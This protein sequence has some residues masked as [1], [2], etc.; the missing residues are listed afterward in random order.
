MN[1]R[2]VYCT[3]GVCGLVLGLGYLAII[4]L[5]APIGAP[6]V[7]VEAVLLYLVRAPVRW[8]WIVVLSVLTDFLFVPLALSIY[9]SLRKINRYTM[10][11]SS[12]CMLLF[13]VL[14][15]AITWTN[16]TSLIAL[17]SKYIAAATEAQ[18]SA[19]AMAAEPPY[20]VLH[21]NLLFV[22][23]T[24]TLAVGILL[25]GTV[26]LRSTFGKRSAYLAIATGLAGTVSVVASFF[27]N[28]LSSM[29]L[30]ASCLTTL[31][32]LVI[33]YQLLR[34]GVTVDNSATS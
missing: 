28:A 23:N 34:R 5:Y 12:G 22:Y 24:L 18:R 30:I 9:F 33:G 21:S 20:A 4:A 16:Y 27:G 13:V 11:L 31:W 6:P 8:S 32:V 2:L 25:T 7:G 29:I 3:G 26:M 15:L 17:S 1:E 10:W 19:I 14:D